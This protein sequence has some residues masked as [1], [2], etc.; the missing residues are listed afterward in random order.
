[1]NR[2]KSIAQKRLE[3]NPGKQVL[4]HAEMQPESVAG[5]C[6]SYARWQKC[7]DLIARDGLLLAEGGG[8]M[9]KN[10]AFT[11]WMAALQQ[12]RMWAIEFG[13]TP[14]SRSRIRL[15]KPQQEDRLEEFLNRGTRPD[16]R[17]N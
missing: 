12:M 17:I 8:K 14:A 3:G 4:N 2:P 1:M 15:E 13:M 7:E 5:Y 11:I 9:R 10:P 6:M 16:D